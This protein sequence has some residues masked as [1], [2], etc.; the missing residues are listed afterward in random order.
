MIRTAIKRFKTIE[1][2][3]TRL[4]SNSEQK[5][6]RSGTTAKTQRFNDNDTKLSEKLGDKRDGHNEK[7]YMYT[8]SKSKS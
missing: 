6:L 7:I 8:H 5:P 1:T 4:Y 3:E 2:D